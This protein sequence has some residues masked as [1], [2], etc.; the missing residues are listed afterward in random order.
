MASL[1]LQNRTVKE[2]HRRTLQGRN[3]T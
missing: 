2:P 1:H 3:L